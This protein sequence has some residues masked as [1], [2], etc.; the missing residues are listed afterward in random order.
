MVVEKFIHLTLFN[1]VKPPAR[2]G[3]TLI[4]ERKRVRVINRLFLAEKQDF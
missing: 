2:E 3:F 4:H 1:P